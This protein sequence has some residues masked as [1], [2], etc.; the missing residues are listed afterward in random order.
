MAFRLRRKQS[1]QR[2]VRMI[3]LEQINKAID[4][5]NDEELDPEETVHQV[6]KRC[7]KLRGLIRLIRPGFADY[8][9]ENVFFRDLAR[10][11]SFLRDTQV[12]T[13]TLDKLLNNSETG[14][15]PGNRFASVRQALEE[16]RSRVTTEAT[17][18]DKRLGKALKKLQRAR[19]RARHWN[20]DKP[21]FSVV[22]SGL[23]KTYERAREELR[24]VR[25]RPTGENYH[26]WRK[27]V[28]YHWYHDRLLRR[29]WRPMMNVECDAGN[30]LSDILGDDHDLVVLRQL[31]LE[32]GEQYGTESDIE[33]LIELID[34]RSGDLRRRAG[35]LG[36][37]LFAEKP[38]HLSERY[39][40]YWKTWRADG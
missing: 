27:R 39:R 20:I 15:E 6:R 26:S 14:E 1:V 28:K 19:R 33:Q 24:H 10:D 4:E 7:K 21:S 8:K 11:L 40:H 9:R 12:S 31:F 34:N 22:E 3:A 18:L 17:D 37:R 36:D 38:S 29:I 30:E 35:P 2:S 23:K 13:E 5:I 25:K 32:N 16:R